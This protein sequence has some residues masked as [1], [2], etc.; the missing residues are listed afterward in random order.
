MEFNQTEYISNFNKDNYK[1]YQF[2]V[3]KS[4]VN[5]IN[6]LDDIENRNSYIISL[7]SENM[8]RIVSV[9]KEIKA[10]IKPILHKYGITNI[11][12]FGSYARGEVNALSDIDIY[13]D[14]GNTKTLID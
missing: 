3:K 14:K 6:Y 8:N 12:L 2:R 13:C 10:I 4:D 11:N 5:I 1:M 7:I 9:I